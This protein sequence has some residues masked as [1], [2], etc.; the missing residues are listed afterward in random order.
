M[1]SESEEEVESGEKSSD[2]LRTNAIENLSILSGNLNRSKRGGWCPL[3][4]RDDWFVLKYFHSKWKV[5]Q[6]YISVHI[7]QCML[8]ARTHKLIKV[9]TLFEWNER[10]GV[11]VCFIATRSRFSAVFIR[12]R[13]PSF[14]TFRHRSFSWPAVTS[15]SLLDRQD[16]SNHVQW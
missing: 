15:L 16:Q 11:L 12:V 14:F 10:V 1:K 13:F 6:I 7:Y 8:P 5:F 4:A 2:C 3:E 9:S